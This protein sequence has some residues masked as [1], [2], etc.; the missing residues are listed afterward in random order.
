MQNANTQ[1]LDA[2]T[3]EGVLLSVNVRYWW[4]QK[5]LAAQDI[6]IA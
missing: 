2:L 5:K 4:A 3:R 6:G 1:Q